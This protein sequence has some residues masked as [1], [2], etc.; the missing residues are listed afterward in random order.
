MQ[1]GRSSNAT[2]RCRQ[3]KAKSG[4]NPE[5]KPFLHNHTQILSDRSRE[6]RDPRTFLKLDKIPNREC[7]IFGRKP[8]WDISG[9]HMS[10]ISPL[11]VPKLNDYSRMMRLASL[12][13]VF[14]ESEN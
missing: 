4:L 12:K 1:Y 7:H 13:E 8:I 3:K 6:T 5:S 10:T 14:N 9:S 11:V 2:C